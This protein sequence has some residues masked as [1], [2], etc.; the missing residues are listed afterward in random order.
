LRLESSCGQ[1]HRKGRYSEFSQ[2]FTAPFQRC[3]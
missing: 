1:Q 3:S 2:H